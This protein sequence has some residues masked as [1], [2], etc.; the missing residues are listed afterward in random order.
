MT[1]AELARKAGVSERNIVRWENDQHAPRVDHIAA[2]AQ[3]TGRDVEFFLTEEAAEEDDVS[4]QPLSRDEFTMLGQLM[5][6]LGRNF[7][8]Q[9]AKA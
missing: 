1:Q 9:E 4:S 5:A 8:G 3:A 2:I 6:R 7:Q